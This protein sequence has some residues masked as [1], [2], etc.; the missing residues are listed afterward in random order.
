MILEVSGLCA[1]ATSGDGQIFFDV[2]PFAR[3]SI[4]PY[5]V[6]T[7]ERMCDVF[8]IR[9][10]FSGVSRFLEDGILTFSLRCNCHKL[11]NRRRNHGFAGLA[12]HYEATL[13]SSFCTTVTPFEQERCLCLLENLLKNHFGRKISEEQV[14]KNIFLGKKVAN[15]TTTTTTHHRTHYRTSVFKQQGYI[16]RPEIPGYQAWAV[17]AEQLLLPRPLSRSLGFLHRSARQ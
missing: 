5:R 7:K 1:V 15:T 12:L 9:A 8:Q 17:R 4:D 3:A 10:L 13:G 14:G 2:R 16:S 6:L 11:R